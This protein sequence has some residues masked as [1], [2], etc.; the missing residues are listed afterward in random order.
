MG[1]VELTLCVCWGLVRIAMQNSG[2]VE[3]ERWHM[4]FPNAFFM[5]GSK[6][7]WYNL[8]MKADSGEPFGLIL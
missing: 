7:K 8:H 3:S 6:N 5:G 1:S 4:C 2:K